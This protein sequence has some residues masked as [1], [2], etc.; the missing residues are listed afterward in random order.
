MKRRKTQQTIRADRRGLR[1]VQEEQGAWTFFQDVDMA[2]QWG[3]FSG[4]TSFTVGGAFAVGDI[5]T[6]NASDNIA[7]VFGIDLAHKLV[8]PKRV[9]PARRRK[10]IQDQKDMMS[11]QITLTSGGSSLSC[12]KIDA[13]TWIVTGDIS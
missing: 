5:I 12:K 6:I 4:G 8:N 2:H 10:V 9:H 3:T 13:S 7:C 1:K 11:D